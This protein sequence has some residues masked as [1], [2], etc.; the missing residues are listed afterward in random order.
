M[1]NQTII[2][3]KQPEL[4]QKIV[5][6]RKAKGMTQEELVERCNINVRTIQR[7][8]AGEVLPRSFTIR[9]IMDA[10]GYDY[11]FLHLETSDNSQM[12]IKK[13][14]IFIKIAFW[15]G[16]VYFL[17][18]IVESVIDYMLW[19]NREET[20]QISDGIYITMKIAVLISFIVFNIG[21]YKL[22]VAVSNPLLK[23][24]SILL[25]V[26]I[27]ISTIGDIACLYIDSDVVLLIQII[28]SVLY[29]A[30]YLVFGSGILMYRKI[31]GSIALVGGI[32][33]ILTGF[34][35]FRD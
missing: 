24:A 29:G 1:V 4:G 26:G 31:Y 15:V 19:E 6:L 14:A 17:L 2:L 23:G 33:G 18:A 13:V 5:E 9:S 8:E 22:T 30:L 7:I 11:Q 10:L 28:K 12:E 3:M 34:W 25:M 35:Q 16:V 32:L 27:V 21:F 20:Y